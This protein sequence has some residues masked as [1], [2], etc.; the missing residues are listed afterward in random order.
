MP[1]RLGSVAAATLGL[2][3]VG[4]L[5]LDRSRQHWA[6]ITAVATFGVV[7]LA[8]FLGVRAGRRRRLLAA[9]ASSVQ[10]KVQFPVRLGPA[11]W[12]PLRAV[13]PYRLVVRYPPQVFYGVDGDLLAG[14]IARQCGDLLSA[15][16]SLRRHRPGRLVLS[17]QA[18]EQTTVSE[19]EE[20]RGRVR[21]VVKQLLGKDAAVSNF[22]A[23]DGEMRAFSVRH[24]AGVKLANQMFQIKVTRIMSAMLPGK[25]RAHY[26][27]ES[28]EA[29]F[30]V[31]PPLP[32][33]EAA[34]RP[35]V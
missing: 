21:H 22:A 4:W 17:R 6:I 28:D 24:T 26:D 7:G 5:L 16:Y 23:V 19:I 15:R 3:A 2:L 34:A 14:Q 9:V 12:H 29:R 32:T 10:K 30:E 11:R 33:F 20:L 13:P 27:L 8:V 25:W 18:P 35:A 1:W 31:R